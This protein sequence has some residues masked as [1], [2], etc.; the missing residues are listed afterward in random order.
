MEPK[1]RRLSR[2]DALRLAGRLLAG[3]A[4]ATG[5]GSLLAACADE[6]ASAKPIDEPGEGVKKT[7]TLRPAATERATSE[8]T[9]AT[10]SESLKGKYEL[11]VKKGQSITK[12]EPRFMHEISDGGTTYIGGTVIGGS[13]EIEDD[14]PPTDASPATRT[15]YISTQ[16]VGPTGRD[17]IL[18]ICI[19]RYV[20]GQSDITPVT[21]TTSKFENGVTKSTYDDANNKNA[22]VPIERVVNFLNTR[23]GLIICGRLYAAEIK[24]MEETSD[25][26]WFWSAKM[27]SGLTRR[28]QFH[29]VMDYLTG[30]TQNRPADLSLPFEF[31]LIMPGF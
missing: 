7:A 18:R 31:S 1:P 27:K 29:Q 13:V 11:Y 21:Y 12:V 20:P 26:G 17:D 16:I 4:L 5:A 2:R 30:K 8:S 28:E 23:G 3:G 25:A 6:S 9:K 22:T 24:I 10:D 19:G 15:V 14:V